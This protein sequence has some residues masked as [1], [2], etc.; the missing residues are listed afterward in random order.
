[1]YVT[2]HSFEQITLSGPCCALK[3]KILQRNVLIT[4][5]KVLCSDS[6]QLTSKFINGVNSH[7]CK[8]FRLKYD[9]VISRKNILNHI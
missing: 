1:M 2:S 5:I 4:Y 9:N 7:H 6:L 8:W 3:Y